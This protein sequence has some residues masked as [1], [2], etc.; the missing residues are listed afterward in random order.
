MVCRCKLPVWVG[1]DVPIP[2]RQSHTVK[3][4]CLIGCMCV[5]GKYV[6]V[7]GMVES[8]RRGM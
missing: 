7:C 3:P 4:H 1:H 6:S 5:G 2:N 8:E